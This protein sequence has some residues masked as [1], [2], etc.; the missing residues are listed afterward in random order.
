MN[1]KSSPS[2]PNPDLLDSSLPSFLEIQSKVFKE[3]KGKIFIGGHETDPAL[4]S[5]LRDEA[6]ALQKTRLWEILNASVLDE[7]YNLA[8]LQ[9]QDWTAVQFAKSLKHWSHFMINVIHKIA[10]RG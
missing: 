3:E 7:A 4:R 9:S 8:L 2:S 10:K 6:E 5:L 1:K